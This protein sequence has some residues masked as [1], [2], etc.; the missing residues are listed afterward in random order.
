M[1]PIL[2]PPN[3]LPPTLSTHHLGSA[4]LDFMIFLKSQEI[5]ESN[6]ESSHDA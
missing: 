5:T 1:E 6:T 4:T 3:P 2:L